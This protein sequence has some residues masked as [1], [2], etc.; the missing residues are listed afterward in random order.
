MQIFVTVKTFLQ[1]ELSQCHLK[2]AVLLPADYI[3][4][5][6][7][8]RHGWGAKHRV[9]ISGMLRKPMPTGHS[10]PQTHNA[11]KPFLSPPVER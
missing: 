7:K 9:H 5:D 3:H 2:H 8:L 11:Q 6:L 1:L 4:L 10:T